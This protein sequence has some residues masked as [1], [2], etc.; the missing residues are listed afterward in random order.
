M[1]LWVVRLY[2]CR[3]YDG[4]VGF[5]RRGPVRAVKSAN[6]GDLWLAAT[7]VLDVVVSGQDELH[8]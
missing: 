5:H 1:H 8:E 4:I 6:I 2:V 3:W 7:D